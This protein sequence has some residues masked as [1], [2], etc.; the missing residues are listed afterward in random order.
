MIVCNNWRER[1]HCGPLKT[2]GYYAGGGAV[3]GMK[4][5]P[6]FTGRDLTECPEYNNTL[7]IRK[8]LR[9][10]K[11]G[12]VTWWCRASGIDIDTR[13]LLRMMQE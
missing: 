7:E 10:F 3:K 13:R 5:I 6:C 1:W 8:L 12:T 9:D 2:C 11:N 4:V